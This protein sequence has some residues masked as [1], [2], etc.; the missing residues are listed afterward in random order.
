LPSVGATATGAKIGSTNRTFQ[1]LHSLPFHRGIKARKLAIAIP[2]HIPHPQSLRP[3]VTLER[4]RLRHNPSF[5][6]MQCGRR[7]NHAPC[8]HMQK[9]EHKYFAKACERKYFLT[10][11]I[12]LPQT[13]SMALQKFIPGST[14]PF[15]TRIKPRRFENIF[16]GTLFNRTDAQLLEF[17]DD[18]LIAPDI[19]LGHANDQLADL[20]LG[21]RATSLARFGSVLLGFLLFPKRLPAYLA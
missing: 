17:A 4:F 18:S 14:S 2:L 1:Y 6:G 19:F 3:G 10:E 11:E 21:P 20:F 13:G 9:H 7:Q 12:C 16:H 8:G 15:G 5:V